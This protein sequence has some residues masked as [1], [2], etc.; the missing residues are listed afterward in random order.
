MHASEESDIGIVPER[1][2]TDVPTAN[3]LSLTS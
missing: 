1:P 3:L 2:V